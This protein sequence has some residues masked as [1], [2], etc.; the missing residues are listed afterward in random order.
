MI[1]I[2]GYNITEEIYSSERSF[3]YRGQR[4]EDGQKVILKVLNKSNPSI[5]EIARYKQEYKISSSFNSA[6]IIKAL[7]LESSDQH[8]IIVFEDFGGI[9]LK[10]YLEQ[11]RVG[12]EEFFELGIAIANALSL[13]HSAHIIHKDI[14]LANIVF[15]SQTGEVKLI[16]FGIS[17]ILFKENTLVKNA[18]ILEGT[19]PYMSPEQ[20]G[21]MNRSLDYRTDF[22]SLGITFYKLLTNQLPFESQDPL[23]LV[24]AHIAKKPLTP[25]QVN[26]KVPQVVSQIVMKLLEKN[27][28]DRYQSATGIKAD[29]ERCLQQFKSRGN[30]EDFKLASQDVVDKFQIPQKLYGREQEVGTLLAVFD[31][32]SGKIGDEI[33][34]FPSSEMVL[35]SG[36]SGVGK[37]VLVQEIYKPITRQRGYFLRG[38]FKKF[39]SN[40]PYSGIIQAFRGLIEQ[41]LTE[42]E[43]SLSRWR[44]KL[45]NVLGSS[46]TAIAKFI[47]EINLI[48]GQNQPEIDLSTEVTKQRFDI[49]FQK[50]IRVF[51]SPRH[52]LVLFLDN[53]QWADIASLKLL[54]SLITKENEGGFLLIGAYRDNETYLSHPLIAT[55]E[56]IVQDGAKT[57]HISL[58]P[59][60]LNDVQH[61]VADTLR[62]DLF[63]AE[64]LAQLIYQKTGGNPFFLNEFLQSLYSKNLIY[65]D[66]EQSKWCWDL[67][68]IQRCDFTDNVVELMA[69][70][71]QNLPSETQYLLKLAACI[72]N[73]FDVE[74]LVTVSGQ[75]IK[76]VV[77][78]LHTASVENLIVPL[79]NHYK[80]IELDII[81]ELK[82]KV[83][84][85]FVHDRIQQAAYSLISKSEKQEL[86]QQIG[87]LLLQNKSWQQQEGK[88][89]DIVNQLNFS[90][91]IIENSKQKNEL[92]KLNLLAGRKAKASANY[93]FA[94]DYLQVGIDL[95]SQDSWQQEYN[96]SLALYE[97]AAE[98]AY[99]NGDFEE[100]LRLGKIVIQEAKN[101]LDKIKIYESDIQ[102]YIA[103]NRPLEALHIAISILEQLGI[104]FPE[105]PTK[106]DIERGQREVQ[107]ALGTKAIE[108]LVDLPL[109]E[110][111]DK[112]A[113]MG[114]VSSAITASY[115]AFPAMMPLFIF[116]QVKLSLEY[117]NTSLSVPAYAY[118]G[119]ILCG[120]FQDVDNGYRFGELALDLLDFLDTKEVKAKTFHIVNSLVKHFR[121]SIRDTLHFSLDAYQ[122]GLETG[123]IE[124]A[125]HGAS[126]YTLH[127]YFLGENLVQFQAEIV[128]YRNTISQLKQQSD[129]QTISIFY[130]VALNLTGNA[131]NPCYLVG[132]AY[133]V[134]VWFPWYIKANSRSSVYLVNLQTSI[135]CYLFGELPKAF[136]NIE[137]AAQDLDVAV[138]SLLTP[139]FHFYAALIKLAVANANDVKEK[140][141]I[142]AQIAEHQQIIKF[143][144]DCAPVNF[145]HKFYLVEAEKHRF[146][147][148]F[149]EAMDSYDNAIALAKETQYL[150]EEALANELAAKFYLSRGKKKIAR[151]YLLDAYSCYLNWGA[152]AKAD[153]LE[154]QYP[155]LFASNHNH[156]GFSVEST[157]FTN[158]STSN[159]YGRFLDLATVIKSSQAIA[160]E[161][162]LD[163]LLAN[164]MAILIENAGAEVGVLILQN[165]GQLF[166]EAV[167]TI[168]SPKVQRW[169]SVL[170]RNTTQEVPVSIIN[171]VARTHESLVLNDAAYEGKFI[172]DAYIRDY[173]PQS[174]LCVPL[175]NQSRLVS[176]IYLENNLTTGA[177]TA[178][179]LEL[180]KLLSSQ[181]A[182]SITNA[183]LYSEVRESESRLT[184]F[185]EAMPVGVAVFDIKGNPYYSNHRA[186]ELLGQ[187]VVPND[188]NLQ[189]SN[190][191][192]IYT[193]GT[194]KVYPQDN[195]PSRRAL[196]GESI[197]VDNIEV[198][199][200]NQAIPL[201]AWGTPI[202]DETGQIAYGISA[203]QDI[204][205]RKKAET[206]R[207]R[208]TEE[209]SQLNKA[210]ERFVPRQFLQLLNKK[211]IA[212]VKLG[213]AVQREMSVLFSDLRSFT[214][215]SEIMNPQDNF[216]FIN[217]FL[218]RME[219]VI[220]DNNGFIDKFIGDAIMA[221]FDG[222]ADD[223]VKAGIAMLKT[224]AEYNKT[225]G[226][227]KRP[228]IKIGIGINTGSLMLGTVGGTNRMEGTVI[229]DAVNLA[230]R[231]EAL[232]KDY[233][234]TLLITQH[235]FEALNNHHQYSIR[236]IDK[237][238]VKGKTEAVTVYEVF[239]A[240]P[241]EIKAAKLATKS[242]F[243][244]GI[245]FYNASKFDEAAAIFQD[246]LT[247]N[248]GDK[249]TQIYLERCQEHCD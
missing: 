141:K 18:Q 175:I 151:A 107:I 92:A 114:I 126:S 124:Y 162:I 244:S 186:K 6:A 62:C 110:A 121:A 59:L 11:H 83:Y 149:I 39:K 41:I 73:Q 158:S 138:G 68:E 43:K 233:Q 231:V 63:V 97:T 7:S 209:L 56:E 161:I 225:R 236:I 91:A 52:P 238:T 108:E 132:E 241:L 214:S 113:A 55:V 100:R 190:T 206:E 240:E 46:S 129:W 3:V 82:Q 77:S 131:E 13:V 50:F 168:D 144:S 159:K 27:A 142:I 65:F 87:Q 23:E 153:Q 217:A 211:S 54:K 152:K 67:K 48:L 38:K 239:D 122:I 139:I 116:E 134:E 189:Q 1:T 105:H 199:R 17:T 119:S 237:V 179:R 191:Y 35:V 111:N 136:D 135:L 203:F 201:E 215:L 193:T 5:E 32:V 123:D 37:S 205:E 145:L 99:L 243:E 230:S 187:G 106:E 198:R 232:T 15:N 53:L 137:A 196:K 19:L 85:R 200:G 49:T 143:L 29:L 182:I 28:E 210:N 88:I 10:K 80:S 242:A 229:S 60:A 249:V 204:T 180:I 70:R 188:S 90:V 118:Y 95:L 176:I 58:A 219:P 31:R 169:Q 30:V 117:G 8:L 78:L 16:D 25:H 2:P 36:F 115:S 140:E 165:K 222:Q 218:S 69:D 195:L 220:A 181:A 109:M 93:K 64:P 24:H 104:H 227:G 173:Q 125:A 147:G 224:I 221:L 245:L 84:Y 157:Q 72:G 202:F 177:F 150:N 120:I 51:I 235:T 71:I 57:N 4:D 127:Y 42:S 148:N 185:L 96:L 155:Q 212:D 192:Q 75:S 166:I 45:H 26:N 216:R 163:K 102:A 128:T 94:L 61:L 226:G 33:S 20:T 194:N 98:V 247:K 22:Y 234:V 74:T 183:K 21:R 66:Y 101:V 207:E 160:G 174:I 246:C 47:P 40:V 133:D 44:N 14:N 223:A 154:N 81:E 184:Q 248:P 167:G 156:L 197:T 170:I 89:F 79:D 34:A 9:S 130:Q 103:Q 171:Y 213:D 146:L 86:H 228:P 172:H 164:L 12:L 76:K 178:D 112:L 208:F